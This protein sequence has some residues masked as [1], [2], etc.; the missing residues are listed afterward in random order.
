MV[1]VRSIAVAGATAATMLLL[2]AQARADVTITETT[3][4]KMFGQADLS[5]TRVTRIKGHKMRQDNN[6]TGGDSLSTIF[7]VDAGKIIVLNNTKK[8]ATVQQT[9]E[10]NQA[11][12]KISDADVKADMTAT[13]ATRTVAGQ[14][15]TVYDANISITFAM[16]EKA[17]PITMTMKG[18]VCLSKSAPGAADFSGFY[19]AASEKGFFFTDPGMVRTQPGMA[20][21]MSTML[22]K[23]AEGGLS[24][25]SDLA[26]DFEGDNMMAQMMKK[27]G[28]GKIVSEATK[29]DT[30]AIADDAFG[31]PAG[32]KVKEGK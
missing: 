7:D 2:G 1:R 22:K 23:L 31:V 29:V 24:L 17:P 4:G 16:M 19:S 30:G 27:M 5:G 25:S 13:S 3:G 18:P 8:E 20:K 26:M 28:G 14:S 15:C 32:Y 9:A 11:L 12:S 6:R 21:G 10:F